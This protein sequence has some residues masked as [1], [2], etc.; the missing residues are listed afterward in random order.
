MANL[1]GKT[2]SGT[3]F[4]RRVAIAGDW[5]LVSGDF[6]R[7]HDMSHQYP[8]YQQL[9]VTAPAALRWRVSMVMVN[10]RPITVFAKAIETAE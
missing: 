2:I 8:Q 6:N 9:P 4:A 5:L 7:N 10:I 3:Y 1:H